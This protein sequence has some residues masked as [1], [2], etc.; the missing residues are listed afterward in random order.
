MN[1]ALK[2]LQVDNTEQAFDSDSDNTIVDDSS[3]SD[4]EENYSIRTV[5]HPWDD[6]DL[7]QGFTGLHG[8]SR[9]RIYN[10]LQYEF[11][12]D[13]N[14]MGVIEEVIEAN[15]PTDD[16]EV[17]AWVKTRLTGNT[18]DGTGHLK[19]LLNQARVEGLAEKQAV[20]LCYYTAPGAPAGEFVERGA[21]IRTKR[22]GIAQGTVQSCHLFFD[23]INIHGKTLEQALQQLIASKQQP[24]PEVDGQP[25]PR[26]DTIQ[27]DERAYMPVG[28]VPRQATTGINPTN[29]KLSQGRDNL[30]PALEACYQQCRAKGLDIKKQVFQAF[31]DAN[32]EEHLEAL[33]EFIYCPTI[34]RE[35]LE[36]QI[37]FF[38]PQE[39]VQTDSSLEQASLYRQPE[40]RVDMLQHDER[41]YVPVGQVPH[42]ATAGNNPANARLS[43][44]RD[45]LDPE[46]ERYYQQCRAKGLDINKQVFQAFVDANREEHLE[47]LRQFIYCPTIYR[48]QIEMQINFF[49]PQET[50]QTDSSL[51][52]ASL[53]PRSLVNPGSSIHQTLSDI[54]GRINSLN[55]DAD[56]SIVAGA[57]ALP[58]KFTKHEMLELH[59]YIDSKRKKFDHI[60]QTC[61]LDALAGVTH[62]EG[63]SLR[64]L[65]SGI[66]GYYGAVGH[67]A[68][69]D[70]GT[71][72]ALK[73]LLN[74][75]AGAGAGAG[76]EEEEHI[77]V[78]D[79]KFHDK[80]ARNENMRTQ[81]GFA[82]LDIELENKDISRIKG[83][84]K[85][86]TEEEVGQIDSHLKERY[87]NGC[88]LLKQS[89]MNSGAGH[90]MFYHP[91]AGFI[92]GG[93]AAYRAGSSGIDLNQLIERF[94][95]ERIGALTFFDINL[96]R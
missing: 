32:P 48:E 15:P 23:G 28:Q 59:R 42:Q 47:A 81:R 40:P 33:K 51:E 80:K 43:Q 68:Q 39:T 25:E 83:I 84:A 5:N 20:R 71:F 66:K 7:N 90:Y 11:P 34:Y 14:L 6:D 86:L 30:D 1:K 26:V 67:D 49:V 38:V 70:A 31:V 96:F 54:A 24:K 36:M 13:N 78:G 57:A 91:K 41:A 64:S 95:L 27:H 74:P 73:Q 87:P 94:G 4:D 85:G 37:N 88:L 29:A 2:K 89:D 93:E 65:P 3:D 69:F 12:N 9:I 19:D 22:N 56:E 10:R 58:E 61:L 60:E 55:R 8:N 16:E 52:Q 53:A 50:V 92:T 17:I 35:Q 45:N 79:K 46:L 21:P 72:L 76:A 75:G 18:E 44:G 62:A 82:A 63:D 77:L